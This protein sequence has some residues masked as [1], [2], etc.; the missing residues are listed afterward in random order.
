MSLGILSIVR[1]RCLQRFTGPID[2]VTIMKI[3]SMMKIYNAH[4]CTGFTVLSLIQGSEGSDL[5]PLFGPLSKLDLPAP[6]V[7]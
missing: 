6:W 1:Y 7:Q 5:P 3:P 4:F 2:K